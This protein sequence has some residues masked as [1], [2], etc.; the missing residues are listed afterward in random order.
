MKNK[1]ETSWAIRVF[2]K[3]LVVCV[4]KYYDWY[5][6]IPADWQSDSRS[7]VMMNRVGVTAL[8]TAFMSDAFIS[9]ELTV[10]LRFLNEE[11]IHLK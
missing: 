2:N 11:D 7:V 5:I 3:N 8:P 9:F 10:R 1:W 4:G 6:L